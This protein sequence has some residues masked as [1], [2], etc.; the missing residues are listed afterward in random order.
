[1]ILDM[2]VQACATNKRARAVDSAM[3]VKGR[4]VLGRAMKARDRAVKESITSGQSED[5]LVYSLGF[6]YTF[7]LRTDHGLCIVLLII[8]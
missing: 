4:A 6:I 8:K 2:I 1:M 7:G 3:L 5:C